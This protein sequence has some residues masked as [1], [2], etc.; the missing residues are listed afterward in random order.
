MNPNVTVHPR[1]GVHGNNPGLRPINGEYFYPLGIEQFEAIDQCFVC[2]AGKTIGK[3]LIAHVLTADIGR[4]IS[5]NFPFIQRE[6]KDAE[7]MRINAC[8][9]HSENLH[10]LFN[11]LRKKGFLNEDILRECGLP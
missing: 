11:V 2:G 6:K 5:F 4:E 8:G 9:Q 7:R 3:T 1:H 10:H